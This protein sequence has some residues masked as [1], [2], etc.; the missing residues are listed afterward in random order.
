MTDQNKENLVDLSKGM[1]KES[2]IVG[3]E[4]GDTPEVFPIDLE[5]NTT[6]DISD[7]SSGDAGDDSGE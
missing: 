2:S 4:E 3:P 1:T 7:D 5:I 6:N